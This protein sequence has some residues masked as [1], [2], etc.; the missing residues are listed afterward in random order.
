MK[1]ISQWSMGLIV[2]VAGIA[3]LACVT[4]VRV[5]AEDKTPAESGSFWMKEKLEYSQRIYKGLALGDYE[6]IEKA[7][8]QLRKLNKIEAFIRAR[9]PAYRTHLEQF[10]KANEEIIRQTTARDLD[11]I[12]AAFNHMTI[13][14]VN[15]HKNLR[16]E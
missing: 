11:G 13:S 6:Q 14:C 8:V 7:A 4:N 16:G 1:R 5:Q 15:C 10:Q 2:A 3:L 12:T 9:N